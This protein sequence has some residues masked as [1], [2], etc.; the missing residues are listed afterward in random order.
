[1]AIEVRGVNKSFGATPVLRDINLSIAKGSTIG[2][3][4]VVSASAVVSGAIPDQAVAQGQPAR[5][6]R[7]RS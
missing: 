6:I 2:N 7:F 1:M 4:A 5:V 3:G